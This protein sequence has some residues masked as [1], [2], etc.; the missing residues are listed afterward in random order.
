MNV[1]VALRGSSTVCCFNVKYRHYDEIKQRSLIV[2]ETAD[3]CCND[4]VSETCNN[5]SGVVELFL[6]GT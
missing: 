4:K 5:F 1:T 2:Y 6:R 3:A